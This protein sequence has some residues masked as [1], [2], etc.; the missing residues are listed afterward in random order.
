MRAL[1]FAVRR[2]GRD[3]RSGELLVLMSALVIA[4]ASMTAIS[5]LTDRIGKA[6]DYQ[7]GEVLAA[8]IRLSSGRKLDDSNTKLARSIGLKTVDMVS[9]PSV[10]FAG[11]AST[12]AR[13]QA[14]T[15]GYPLRGELRIAASLFGQDRVAE[16]I[17][18]PGTLYAEPA[19]LTRLGID[20]GDSLELGRLT[21]QVAG[22]IAYRPDQSPGFS[23]L[24]P[25]ILINMA[26][27][28][29]SGLLVEGSRVGYYQLFGGPPTPV[30][31]F[32]DALQGAMPEGA[33]MQTGAEEGSQ[34]A[35]A[36]ERAGGFLSLASLVSLILAAVAIAMSAQRYAER[37]LDTAALMKTFGASQWFVLSVGVI[38]ILL[39]AAIGSAIG[40][41]TG[42]YAERGLSA[43]L[44]GWLRGDLPQPRLSA[45]WPGVLSALVLLLGFALPSLLRL[46]RTPPMRVL[47]H[48][49]APP[50]LSLWV[51]YGAAFLAIGAIVAWAVRDTRLLV[52]IL[53]GTAVTAAVLFFAGRALVA[54]LSQLRGGVGV[55]WRYGLANV[56]RR[57]STSA[58]QV[59]AFGLGLMVLLLLTLVHDDLLDIWRSS[60]ADDAP[61]Q[62]LINILPEERES[63]SELIDSRNLPSVGYVPLVRGRITAVNDTPAEDWPRGAGEGPVRVGREINLS[64][65]DTLDESNTVIEG[66]FWSEGDGGEPQVSIDIAIANEMGV[67]VGDTLTF[68][69]A[70]LAHR[71]TITS[72]R[73]ID[74]DSFRPNFFI[75]L[76]PTGMQDLP[77]TFLNALFVGESD[78]DV[79]VELVRKHPSVS[80]IDIEAAIEQIRGIIDKAALAV[81]YVFYFTIA[82]GL[83]VLFAAI[84]STLESRRYESALLRTFGASRRVVLLGILAEFSALG[85]LAGLCASLGATAIGHV[86]ATEVFDLQ[87]SVDP[88]LWLIGVLAGWLVVGVSGTLA[89]R[90]AVETPPVRTLRGTG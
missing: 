46:R 41:A 3:V 54:A 87:L 49:M 48:D 27:I 42:Y 76:S 69:F 44:T 67:T 56:A 23:G 29:P 30:R 37:R 51:S 19:L 75:V 78:K 7:A 64:Y 18:L 11:E 85:L 55:S 58:I 4:V 9:F 1:V 12:L 60:V 10:T 74:W 90:S 83:V 50:P 22:V 26:D 15:E 32:R 36:V 84:Q 14:V 33:T 38:H 82:A 31:K 13:L 61:N 77:Q 79:L 24:A 89:A 17:P 34:L 68:D 59:V 40:A 57:G 20:V 81:R 53:G 80:V 8:D 25:T 66:S 70:G 28:E 71:A 88:V 6:V 43:L 65:T 62:F 45:M 39:I 52:I 73:T 86:V 63:I 21:L 2:F 72:L 35:G 16:R 5:F 47:R